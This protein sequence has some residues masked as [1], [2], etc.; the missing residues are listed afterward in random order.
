MGGK[1]I[2][3]L[4]KLTDGKMLSNMRARDKHLWEYMKQ[5]A[6]DRGYGIYQHA[7]GKPWKIGVL[8]QA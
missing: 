3:V 8:M 2:S 4:S 1:D 6:N 7:K 5:A